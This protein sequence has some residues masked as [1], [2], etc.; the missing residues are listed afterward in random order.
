VVEDAAVK[1]GRRSEGLFFAFT[2]LIQKA[3]SGVGV[4]VAGA[5]LT[6]VSFPVGVKPADIDG[7]VVRNLALVYMP[8]LMILYGLAVGILQAY[9]ITR[10]R[11][12]ENLRLLKLQAQVVEQAASPRYP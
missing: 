8:V 9:G 5:L 3:V 4:M 10:E 7:E 2:S 11:H 12:T 6:L 1:T